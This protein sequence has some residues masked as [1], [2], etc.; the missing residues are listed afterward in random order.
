MSIGG[1]ESHHTEYT[2]KLCG[3]DFTIH[4]Y[5]SSTAQQI[6]ELLES[7]YTEARRLEKIFNIYDPNSEISQLNTERTLRVSRELITVIQKSLVMCAA[8]HGAY[9]IG[10]GAVIAQRKDGKIS[11]EKSSYTDIEIDDTTVRLHGTDVQ[12]DL[13]SIAKGYIVDC[14]GTFLQR[15]GVEN[16]LIDARGDI[17]AV[18]E[19][20]H[21][22]GIQDPRGDG[23]LGSIVLQ[24]MSVAT[25]GDYKQFAG[26]P[27]M[28]H[29]VNQKHLSS[30]TVITESAAEADMFATALFVL[31]EE[32]IQE[33][34]KENPHI[35][36]L[37][38]D[39]HQQIHYYNDVQSYLD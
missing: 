7:A 20:A 8:T 5:S 23:S 10:I 34:L 3:G 11:E 39:R 19:Y 30:V 37:S 27:E 28:S 14:V 13:G 22:I 38:I 25:S 17:K 33:L 9:D 4:A 32:D 18:G 29:I 12:L 35:S 15:V 21:R 24:N 1:I 26:T 31:E 16:A 36:V 2:Q 6:T